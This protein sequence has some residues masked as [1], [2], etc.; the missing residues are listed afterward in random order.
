MGSCAGLKCC[1]LIQLEVDLAWKAGPE[2]EAD[3]V[4]ETAA[5]RDVPISIFAPVFILV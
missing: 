1:R 3:L 4:F 5:Y 2:Q